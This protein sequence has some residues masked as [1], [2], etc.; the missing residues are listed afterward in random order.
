MHPLHQHEIRLLVFVSLAAIIVGLVIEQVLLCLSIALAIYIV[1]TLRHTFGLHQWLTDRENQ[2]L[3]EAGGIWGEVFNEIYQM[4]KET[5][6]NREHLTE[7]L[8]RFQ[9][10]AAAL[11]DGTVILNKRDEIEWSNPAANHMLGITCPD[12]AGQAVGNLIRQPAFI[13]YL[14]QNDFSESIT[15][16]SPVNPEYTLSLQIIPYGSSQKLIICRDI[17]HVIRLEEMR[18]NFVA[19]VSHELRSPITVISGYLETLQDM[20]LGNTAALEKVFLNMS[21]QAKRM[22]RLVAD[23]LMLT[24][25]E[26]EPVKLARNV[27]DMAAL[28]AALKESAALISHARHKISLRVEKGLNLQ[29]SQEELHSLFNNLINNAVRYTPEGGSIDIVWEGRGD[30]AVFSVTDT[31]PGIPERHIPHLTERFYRVDI[32]RSRETGGTGL[33]LAIVKHILQR[34]HARLEIDSEIG[35]GSTFRCI[36][37]ADRLVRIA[38]A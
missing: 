4:Q 18:R 1:F 12:D 29:G 35:K 24:K 5:A 38:A 31:G 27:V 3:P 6:K 13:E 22:E 10:A 32:D 8:T 33:G 19:N 21:G 11:P 26:T 2:K 25:L 20:D 37:P 36:F 23:L 9:D 16:R 28:L 7:A 30:T 14:G 15:I 34:Y 17:T